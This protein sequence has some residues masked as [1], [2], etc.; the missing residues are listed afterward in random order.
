MPRPLPVLSFPDP[1]PGR[2]EEACNKTE[3][4]KDTSTGQQALWLA[5]CL[6]K[7]A[8]EVVAPA[9]AGEVSVVVEEVGGRRL[10]HTPSGPAEGVGISAGMSL[11]AAY[12][13]CPGLEVHQLDE[14]ARDQRLQELAAWA[15]QFS[16]AI[17]LHPPCSL[18]LEAGGSIRYFGGLDAIRDA[19]ALELAERRK[20]VFCQATT[21][22]PAAS[23]MLAQAGYDPVVNCGAGLRSALG[24]LSIDVLP[25]D[26][27]RKQQ[28][29]KTGVRVL[30]DLWRLPA[31][32]LARRFGTGLVAHLDRALGKRPDP[33]DTYRPS[34]RFSVT[35]EFSFEVGRRQLLLPV[36]WELV[37]GLCDFLHQ[38]DLYTADYQVHFFHR[39]EP[40]TTVHIGLR[41][42]IRRPDHLMMLLETKLGGAGPAAAVIR[43]TLSAERFY[44]VV[45]RSRCLFPDAGLEQEGED[46]APLL[47][48]LSARLDPAALAGITTHADHRPE[49]AWRA[50]APAGAGPPPPGNPRPLWLL[51]KPRELLRKDDGVYYRSRIRFLLGPER[52]EAGWWDSAGIRRDYYVGMDPVAGRLWIY[53]DLATG[54]KWYLHGLFG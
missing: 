17:S 44:R 43:I 7:L 27:K 24:P 1:L 45:P 28:L 14:V 50:G 47:E 32:E 8:L 13:C 29:H 38:Q 21:P 33:L 12:A 2:E 11:S 20:H 46:I 6:P 51:P 10:V 4:G 22:T 35:R 3:T 49:Y 30:R 31:G 54:Q 18:L 9:G 39:R 19:I 41:Q 15:L 40:V 25:L 36:V 42:P 37:A 26:D 48:R 23:L 52:I 5:V 34:P 16:P 53:R